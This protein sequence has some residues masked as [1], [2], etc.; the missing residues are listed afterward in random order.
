MAHWFFEL[1][2]NENM[3]I[4]SRYNVMSS[5]PVTSDVLFQLS[6]EKFQKNENPPRGKKVKFFVI[7]CVT[8]QSVVAAVSFLTCPPGSLC[9]V[10]PLHT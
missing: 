9:A 10:P 6:I 5:K 2:A 8:H 4:L 1:N 7:I 3:L